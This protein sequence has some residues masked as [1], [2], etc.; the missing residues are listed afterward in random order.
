MVKQHTFGNADLARKM[1][2]RFG[3]GG[4]ALKVKMQYTKEVRSFISKIEEAHKKAAQ[5]KIKFD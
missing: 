4:E 1:T 2:S 3:T 5:S